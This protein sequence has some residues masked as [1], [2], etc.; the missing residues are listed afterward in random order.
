MSQPVV[1]RTGQTYYSWWAYFPAA[2]LDNLTQGFLNIANWYEQNNL[3][4]T[5]PTWS[6]TAY[7]IGGGNMGLLIFRNAPVYPTPHTGP[8]S[9]LTNLPIPL[10]SWVN[11][12]VNYPNRLAGSNGSGPFQIWQDGNLVLDLPNQIGVEG[13]SLVNLWQLQIYGNGFPNPPF[14]MYIDDVKISDSRIADH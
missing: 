2:F 1:F 10:G 3:G 9:Y 13:S 6:I 14:L 5:A 7:P 8:D 4:G 11:F 12:E